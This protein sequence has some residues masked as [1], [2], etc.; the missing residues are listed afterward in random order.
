MISFYMAS[1]SKYPLL[2][3][4]QERDVACSIA[5]NRRNFRRNLLSSDLT[6]QRAVDVLTQIQSGQ[7]RMD[8]VLE[9]PVTNL[10]GKQNYRR[11]LRIHL[12]TLRQ[13]VIANRRDFV[14]AV[15]R[16]H[17]DSKRRAAWQRMV[18]RRSKASRLI[19]E[20]PL[21]IERIMEFHT[22]LL[23]ARSE[24]SGCK[25][26]LD[27]A[28]TNCEGLR[29]PLW[30]LSF[31]LGETPR[32]M[33]RICQRI[34]G[35]RRD[36]EQAKRKLCNGNLRLVVSIAKKFMNRNL[37]LQDLIQEGNAGLIRAADKFQWNR[38]VKFATYATW[39]IRQAMLQAL[40]ENTNI[41]RLPTSVQRRLQ[42]TQKVTRHWVQKNGRYPTVEDVAQAAK[43]T[44]DEMAFFLRHG[45]QP[46]SLDQDRED[47]EDVVLGQIMADRHA[48]TPVDE[49]HIQQL[50]GRLNEIMETLDL[51]ERE[52]ISL[53]FG[54]EHG[55]SLNLR[56]IG[57]VF[58]LSR[59]RIRQIER[60]A[61]RKLKQP[62][63]LRALSG[64]LDEDNSTSPIKQAECNP[65]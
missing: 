32:T 24:M 52:V 55:P 58:S 35:F 14:I 25:H 2:T 62:Y 20:L 1:V 26:R 40:T 7:L 12:V 31:A 51:R 45:R 41:V 63:H 16:R 47:Q 53:R 4:C 28:V 23:R 10:N 54:L 3:A 46:L 56:Q 22:D 43:M 38:G 27:N 11:I 34:G 18:R 57:D 49:L 44:N 36:Y 33:E 15:N 37:N 42:Q 29:R 65:D 64:F 61:L 19:E 48:K 13:L 60:D 9:I 21:R 30:E 6:I 17:T 5:Y 8:R 59:E 39:W 50:R